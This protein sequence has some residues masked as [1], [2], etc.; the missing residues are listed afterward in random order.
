MARMR[1]IIITANATPPDGTSSP[2]ASSLEE[3]AEGVVADDD[4]PGPDVD[5][6]VAVLDARIELEVDSMTL[7]LEVDGVVVDE[8]PEALPISPL[9]GRVA[10]PDCLE[11]AVV[12]LTGG[13]NVTREALVVAAPTVAVASSPSKALLTALSML[14]KMLPCLRLWTC[15]GTAV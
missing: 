11:D 14:L 13:G 9:D 4:V 2:F 12:V 15:G 10:A 5:I 1:R 8:S 7:G 3:V 6:E